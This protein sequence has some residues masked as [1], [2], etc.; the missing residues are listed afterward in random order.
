MSQ[1]M[2]GFRKE[3]EKA[4]SSKT[5]KSSKFSRT[6]PLLPNLTGVKKQI[7]SKNPPATVIN[8]NEKEGPENGTFGALCTGGHVVKYETEREKERMEQRGTR[9][10]S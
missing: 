1:I 9:N 10:S 8:T 3:K 7:F 6:Y 4:V 2:S 5:E